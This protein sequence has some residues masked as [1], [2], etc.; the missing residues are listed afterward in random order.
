MQPNTETSHPLNAANAIRHHFLA[1]GAQ[2]VQFLDYL[3]AGVLLSCV[4][5]VAWTIIFPL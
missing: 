3:V 1:A 4:A 5:A 2:L